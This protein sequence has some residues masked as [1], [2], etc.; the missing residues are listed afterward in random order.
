MTTDGQTTDSRR[1]IV[2]G[3]DEAGFGPILGPLVIGATAWHVPAGG[4]GDDLWQRLRGGVS[5]TP[6]RKFARLAINDSKKIYSAAKG[7]LELE[8]GV[9]GTL[10]TQPRAPGGESATNEPWTA[11]TFGQFLDRLAPGWAEQA[12]AHPWYAGCGEFALPVESGQDDLATRING[13]RVAMK[14]GNVFFLGAGLELVCEARFNQLCDAM[15]NKG[16]MLFCCTAR[17][18]QRLIARF[19]GDRLKVVCD[20]HGGRDSYRN[21]LLQ[22]W[23]DM[24]LTVLV[25]S[26]ERSGYRL[27]D[28]G[29][30]R[31]VELWFVPKADV[32]Y[33]PAALASMYCKY[34]REV[35]MRLLN[36]FWQGHVGPGLR[37]TAGYYTDGQRFVGEVSAAAKR[38]GL[39]A[40]RFIRSR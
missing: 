13:L 28:P 1:T 6:S 22:H 39:P 25:E 30:G 20:K 29:A 17:L 40:E 12:A 35:F 38:L 10:A 37:A 16:K 7:L 36:R 2:A 19:G 4:L 3:V 5:K 27:S 15:N 8:R 24:Q 9:L 14:R 31:E 23:P 18:I 21:L 32:T 26:A 11:P 33:L 34:T